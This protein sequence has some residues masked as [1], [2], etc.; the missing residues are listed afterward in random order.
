MIAGTSI[1]LK[2]YYGEDQ[3]PSLREH[4]MLQMEATQTA[5]SV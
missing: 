5:T 3:N 1:Y 4:M 2:L